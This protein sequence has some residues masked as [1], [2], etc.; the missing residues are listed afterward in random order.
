MTTL[1]IPQLKTFIALGFMAA[2]SVNQASA[3]LV[4]GLYADADYWYTSVDDTSDNSNRE[5]EDQ[6]QVMLSASFEH[7]VPF[8]PN[9][10][11]RYSQLNTSASLTGADYEIESN[12]IDLIGYYELLDTVVSADVGLGA[13]RLQGDYKSSGIVD[14]VKKSSSQSLDKTMPMAYASVGIDLPFSGL[15]TKAELGV[16]KANDVNAIDAQA[17]LKYDFID[18][19]AMDLGAKIGYR[20]LQINYDDVG[21]RKLE[22]EYKGPYAGIEVH[23]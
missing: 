19:I 6:G 7:I 9:V 20:M 4:Y 21:G 22:T 8:V 1:Q 16:A 15:S 23:F 3:D 13:K 17:E 11:G 2:L 12:N 5:Y 14:G 10:R 18:T